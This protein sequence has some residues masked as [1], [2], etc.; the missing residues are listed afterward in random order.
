MEKPKTGVQRGIEGI[1]IDRDL[2]GRVKK[3]LEGYRLGVDEVGLGQQ[4]ALIHFFFNEEPKS[5][6]RFA[7]LW[8][9]AEYLISIGA[10]RLEWKKHE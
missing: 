7:E 5:V 1:G 3:K 10:T 9:R 2:R 8:G 4:M 6:E